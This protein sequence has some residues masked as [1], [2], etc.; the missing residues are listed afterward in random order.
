M[1]EDVKVSD[2]QKLECTGEVKHWSLKL[3]V[4]SQRLTKRDTV[5]MC[6]H[7]KYQRCQTE[8]TFSLCLKPI[9]LGCLVWW[10]RRPLIKHDLGG[11]NHNS[12]KRH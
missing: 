1:S 10:S 7:P 3:G 5:C 2:G 4:Q 6:A 8:N 11:I 9:F 12:G